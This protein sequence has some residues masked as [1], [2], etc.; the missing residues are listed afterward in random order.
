MCQ[1]EAGAARAARHRPGPGSARRGGGRR[2][3]G[4]RRDRRDR[5]A[6]RPHAGRRPDRRARPRRRG[7][8]EALPD[9]FAWDPEREDEFERA[10]RDG[11]QPPALP[12]SPGGVAAS[13]ERTARWRP[14]D[15]GGGRASA[16]VDADTL[17]GLVF[18]ESAGRDD[19]I[20]PNGIEGAVGLTQILAETA[21]EPARHAGRHGAQRPARRAGSTARGAR[22]RAQVARAAPRARAGRRALRRRRRRSPPPAR[23]LKLARETLGR[24]DLAFVSY[25][26]GI[27]NLQG[28]LRAF[29]EGDDVSYAQLYF[30]S[31]LRPPPGGATR[32]SP[33]S[34]TTPRTT[35]GRSLAAR[36]IMRLWRDDRAEL[37]R[38]AACTP[39]RAR[40]RRSCTRDGSVPRFGDPEAAARRVGRGDIVAFPDA[41]AVTGLRRDARMGELAGGSTQPAGALPRAAA[42]GARAGALHRRPGARAQRRRRR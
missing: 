25:H 37:D 35:T 4:R 18:L 34:A 20:T 9:P 24:E 39:P 30:D 13:A 7:R 5:R 12:L 6:R 38:L 33:G 21:T 23:Y 27:G 14:A 31:T 19:A 10:R 41:P 32:G 42:R 22:P 8:A 11:H 2:A 36:E 15:R 3:A 29:G 1:P 26:M 17:E 40:P 28:V 16:D